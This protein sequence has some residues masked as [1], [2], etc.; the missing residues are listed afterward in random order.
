MHVYVPAE[1]RDFFSRGR[2]LVVEGWRRHLFSKTTA[3]KS[4]IV[5]LVCVMIIPL[6]NGA[7]TFYSKLEYLFERGGGGFLFE[8]NDLFEFKMYAIN[9]RNKPF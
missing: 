3:S 4:A 9:K 1:G 5:H 2:E 6:E 7:V 8:C